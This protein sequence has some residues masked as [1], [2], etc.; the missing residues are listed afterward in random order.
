MASV[1]PAMRETKCKIYEPNSDG[2]G[3]LCLWG[4]NIMMGYLN[5]EDKTTE[6]L[7]EEGWLHSGDVASMDKDGYVFITGR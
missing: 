3:E 7:D 5:R 2:D 4:R 6:D 1:G